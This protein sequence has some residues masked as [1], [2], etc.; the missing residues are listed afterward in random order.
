MKL[1]Y[2]KVDCFKQCPF[3]YK[4]RYI[5]KLEAIFN[6]DPANALILGTAVHEGIEKD[7]IT[8]INGYY[9]NYPSVTQVMVNE[10]IK[11]EIM[12]KKARETLPR[13][14][15]ELELNSEDF[16]GFIDLLVEVD[17][18]TYDL[19]DFKYSNNREKYME[20]AQLH[21]YKTFFEIL[22]PKKRI[23]NLYF[24]F[25][26]KI[27]IKQEQYESIEDYRKRLKNECMKESIKIVPIDYNQN[28]VV[29]F[30]LN[31]K[32]M[33]ECNEYEKKTSKLCYFCDYKNY[34]S[35]NGAN[36]IGIKKK[37]ESNF[38]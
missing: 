34:C 26:P 4:L 3:Q 38:T 19:Y 2:S 23:R 1:S 16:I 29:E 8:A 13:G 37:D 14:I 25:I 35:S 17:E 5:D 33:L 31:A 27:G 30:L 32:H 7:V 15:Y 36:M 28:K 12:I 9:S 22:N 21:V 11:L 20:S 18:D 24:V 6:L 10:A